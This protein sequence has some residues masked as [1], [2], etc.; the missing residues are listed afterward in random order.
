MQMA[1]RYLPSGWPTRTYPVGED[2]AG[3]GVGKVRKYDWK[4]E[5]ML[6]LW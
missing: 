6:L 1:N 5:S 3:K 2:R 4:A